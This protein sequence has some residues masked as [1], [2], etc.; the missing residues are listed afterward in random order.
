[1][2]G[3]VRGR[4]GRMEAWT[5]HRPLWDPHTWQKDE[6]PLFPLAISSYLEEKVVRKV[7]ACPTCLPGTETQG[8]QEGEAQV[9]ISFLDHRPRKLEA[10][11]KS[12]IWCYWQRQPPQMH[13]LPHPIAP[14]TWDRYH[15]GVSGWGPEKAREQG[16]SLAGTCSDG[17]GTIVLD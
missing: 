16:S 1:M 7:P 11:H 17:M 8:C 3:Q 9:I 13:S 15:R 6:V 10:A 5:R 12:S 2:T 14:S 4:S